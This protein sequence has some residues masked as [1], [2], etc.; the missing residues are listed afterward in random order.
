MLGDLLVRTPSASGR[1]HAIAIDG[2]TATSRSYLQAVHRTD[3][4]EPSEHADIGGWY[5]HAFVRDEAGWRIA[6]MELTFVW[7]AGAPFDA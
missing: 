3:E 5:D 1:D 7:T 2:D 6:S 4:A